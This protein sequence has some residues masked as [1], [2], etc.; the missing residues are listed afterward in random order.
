VARLTCP[1][2]LTGALFK[3][4]GPTLYQRRRGVG[5]SAGPRGGGFEDWARPVKAAGGLVLLC[6]DLCCCTVGEGGGGG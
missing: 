2:A 1:L 5:P 6:K 3:V 4:S